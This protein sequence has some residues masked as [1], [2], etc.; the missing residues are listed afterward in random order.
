MPFPAGAKTITVTGAFPSPVGGGA[1]GGR[2]VF[3]P[4]AVLVDSTQHAI[5]SGGGPAAITN[6]AM[7]IVLLCTDDADVQP[8]GWRWRVDEQPTSGQRRTYYI[9]LPSTLGS[10][11]S[12][13]VLA[14]VSAPDG[15]AGGGAVGPQGPPGPQ[16]PAGPTGPT[17]AQG[18]QGDTGPQG[19]AGATGATGATG[20]QGPAG[21]QGLQGP[22]G[23][24]G[25]P[26]RT[27]EL[28]ISDGAVQ[29]LA[30]AAS[31]T[32][33]ATSVGTQLKCS[34]AAEPG[35][36][37]RV[38]L[39][40]LYSGTRYLDL[41]L[42]DSAGAIA[43]YGGSGTGTPLAE[44]TPEF[45]PSTS[46]GK[47]TSGGM[48]TV[49]A[50]HLASGQA[51]I[52][53]VN[54]GTGAGRV[55]AYSGYPWRMT[56][57]NLGP[58]PA[59]SGIS[60]AQTSTPVTG[61]VKYAPAGVA[62]SGSDVTGPF[63]YLGAGGFQIGVGTPDSTYVLPTTRYPNTR[64]TLSSSQSIWSVEFGT[65]ATAFQLRFN[66]Q[67]GGSYRI[68]ID[69]RRMTD[70]MQSVGGTTP[71]STHLMTVSLGPA[72]PRVIRLDFAVV[73][74]GGVYLPPGATMWK[75]PT[76][77]S[78]IMV[79]GDS[80]PGGS[81]MNSGGG[82]GTWFPRAA[83]LL[84]Y[85][86]AWNEALGSTGYITAGSTA[87]LGTRAPIDVIPNSPD[88][89]II[90]AGYN[91]N[92]GSQP[93]I[94]SAAASLY[95]AVKT[96]LPNARIYVIGCWSPSGSPASSI[97]NTDTTL[98]T[99]AAAANLPFISPITGRIYDSTGALIAT[100]G[101]WITGT[102]RVGATTG[103]GNADTYIGTD[104]THPTDVGHTYLASRVVAAIQELTA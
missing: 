104:A 20:A 61:Y 9:D 67:T 7:S 57:T 35:D 43:Q 102:G 8:A 55:Y 37:I 33:A 47:A 73:P 44:G 81:S 31:W 11:I 4:T 72:Q 93:A 68:S 23:A 29:D 94:S 60:V 90:S 80:I 10:T 56:L 38:D 84:G 92:A 83:R 89:L 30:A 16:G 36:R 6:G 54:Q 41:A 18:P 12:L 32:I 53:L 52:A 78:R 13:D 64:G 103:S 86:D 24:D 97:T 34:I 22:A 87:T 17:G 1:R 79:L 39:G 48:F 2:V 65:D 69:G 25:A 76:P 77:S 49:A 15:G 95:S 74:F 51:T 85:S 58:A 66:Y 100:H 75:P 63:S 40:M 14:P 88:V 82:A 59:P 46:F 71:G 101:P 5:Y 45:Y 42:L 99:A 98:R 50:S 27:A 26:P 21:A 19:P 70:L 62:L 96:G 28:R 3:T 91:D